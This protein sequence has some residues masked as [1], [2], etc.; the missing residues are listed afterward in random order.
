MPEIIHREL[1]IKI[2]VERDFTLTLFII[3]DI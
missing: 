3:V 2:N 1:T